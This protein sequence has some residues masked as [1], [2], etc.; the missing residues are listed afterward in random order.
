M[1]Q[2]EGVWLGEIAELTATK[3]ADVE[4]VKQFISRTVDDYR[5]AYARHKTPR[6]RQCIFFGTTNSH[7]FLRDMTGNRR[8]LVIPIKGYKEATKNIWEELDVDQVWAEVLTFYKDEILYVG[9]D[10][11]DDARKM[12]EDHLEE[13]PKAGMIREFLERK[14]PSNW[15]GLQIE[16]RRNFIHNDFFDGPIEGTEVRDKVCVAEIWCEL[17]RGDLKQLDRMTSREIGDVIRS[18]D[19]WEQIST[20]RFGDLYGTQRGF[21][22]KNKKT[23]LDDLALEMLKDRIL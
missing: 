21:S 7:E 19:G 8:Y 2:L 12:Q 18:T 6:P 3:R 15:E 17:F 13:S 9:S 16:E 14:L 22:R 10:I 1:E 4:A 11:E 20:S 5:P 23:T